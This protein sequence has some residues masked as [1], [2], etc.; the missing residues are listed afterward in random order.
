[1]WTGWFHP[2]EPIRPS[3]TPPFLLVQNDGLTIIPPF[4]IS[5]WVAALSPDGLS[6]KNNTKPAAILQPQYSFQGGGGLR[7]HMCC[8]SSA[9]KALHHSCHVASLQARLP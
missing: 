9:F 8:R 2:A 7:I 4:P 1:M 6:F 5:L 3:L